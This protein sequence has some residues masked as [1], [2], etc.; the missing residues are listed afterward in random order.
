MDEVYFGDF[1]VVV[2]QH[3]R[4][5]E[6]QNPQLQSTESFLLKYLRRI[7]KNANP[8]SSIGEMENS[9]RALVRF[10]VDTIEKNSP[11]GD[12]FVQI[13]EEYRKT[14]RIKKQE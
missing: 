12:R 11:L 10:Y 1:R 5:I 7:E 3:I 4:E 13:Y 14:L 9:I 6:A 8:P 2:I